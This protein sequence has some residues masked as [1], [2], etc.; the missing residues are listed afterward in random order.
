MLSFVRRAFARTSAFD[1]HPPIA[2]RHTMADK[3][4]AFMRPLGATP[5]AEDMY[6][7]S[8]TATARTTPYLLNAPPAEVPPPNGKF[9]FQSMPLADGTRIRGA[10]ADIHREQRLWASCF[11]HDRDALVGKRVLDLG[12][13]DGF[14]T[15]ASLL[16]GAESAHAVNTPELVHGTFPTNL[17][18]A[19]NEWGLEPEITVGDLLDLPADGP[20]YDV[21]LFFGVFYMMENVF[22]AMRLLGKLLSPG[23]AVFLETQT[24]KVL[25]D[26]PVLEVA[27]D[28]YPGTVPQ[29]RAAG[30]TLGNSNYL[31]PNEA[32]VRA[33]AS[34]CG[35][36]ANPLPFDNAY[37]D[38]HGGPGRRRVFILTR[39]A[40]TPL[41]RKG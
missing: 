8:G 40:D 23:G 25:A 10:N 31:I 27:S 30:D 36:R 20:R 28:L 33:V 24:T 13:N 16:C 19:A 2:D 37:E 17:R 26:L 15:L 18:W 11:G 3:F 35:L 29:I 1:P 6:R 34:T 14:F 41:P 32:A 5:T 12:A 21:V 4:L 39:M 38:S 9:W 22:S 7:T